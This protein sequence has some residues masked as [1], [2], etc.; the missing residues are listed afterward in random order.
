TR[1]SA[2]WPQSDLP[3]FILVTASGRR[4]RVTYLQRP[5]TACTAEPGRELAQGLWFLPRP[6]ADLEWAPLERF[7]AAGGS[8]DCR[9]R[10]SH[11]S[12]SATHAGRV[13]RQRGGWADVQSTRAALAQ[14]R[15]PRATHPARLTQCGYG[16]AVVK[17]R[18][19]R[20]GARLSPRTARLGFP[21]PRPLVC[22]LAPKQRQRS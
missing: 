19:S 18:L 3:R 8:A 10:P 13:R 1:A 9:C 17:K 16:V 14:S 11:S 5:R 12:G 20:L 6:A 22:G 21:V 2:A 15:P 4:R 7:G